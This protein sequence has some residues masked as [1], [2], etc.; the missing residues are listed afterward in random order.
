MI[1]DLAPSGGAPPLLQ[2]GKSAPPSAAP[3][4]PVQEISVRG[5]CQSGEEVR[6]KRCKGSARFSRGTGFPSQP[7]ETQLRL[8]SV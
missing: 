3:P 6:R 1:C 7:G 8:K 2:R 4:T 5:G